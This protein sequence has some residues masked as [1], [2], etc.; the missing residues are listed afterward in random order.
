MLNTDTEFIPVFYLYI[1]KEKD[2]LDYKNI[3]LELASSIGK[4]ITEKVKNR[5]KSLK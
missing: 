2:N 4:S 3:K 1:L 5:L